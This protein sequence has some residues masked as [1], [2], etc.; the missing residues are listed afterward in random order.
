M[1]LKF[2]GNR[3]LEDVKLTSTSN[4]DF[5]G[6]VF[7]PSKRQVTPEDVKHWLNEVDIKQHQQIVGVFVN[8]TIEQIAHAVR[9]A[10]L[11]IVQLHGN[12]TPDFC[13]QVKDLCRVDVWKVIH[14]NNEAI[15]KMDTYAHVVDGFL[16]DNKSKS[17][18]G[19]TGTAFDWSF[20]P[21]YLEKAR[22]LNKRCLIAGGVNASNVHEL[23]KHQPD[24]IDLA[25]GIETDERKDKEKIT[26]LQSR[27]KEFHMYT[28]STP[29]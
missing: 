14:H 23:L 9:T 12:E 25:S 24:G 6:F 21:R 11:D 3:S 7:A 20:V 28:K 26:K 8:E 22:R 18:W 16:I 27:I 29:S 15:D 10:S 1:K 13:Q 19:G 5:I 4:A 17:Q 2:C